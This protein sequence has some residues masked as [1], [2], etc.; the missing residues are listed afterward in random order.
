MEMARKVCIAL[1]KLS[2]VYKMHDQIDTNHVHQNNWF[3]L[4]RPVS[5]QACTTLDQGAP[6]RRREKFFGH[7]S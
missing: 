4:P 1:P 2:T 3:H 7:T 6:G 5:R